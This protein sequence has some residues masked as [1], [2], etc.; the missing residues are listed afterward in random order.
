MPSVDVTARSARLLAGALLLG[1]GYARALGYAAEKNLMG[2]PTGFY[3]A[4]AAASCTTALSASVKRSQTM[5]T[6]KARST[7]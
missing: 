4:A 7:A 3:V 6:A 5:M 1:A 2:S